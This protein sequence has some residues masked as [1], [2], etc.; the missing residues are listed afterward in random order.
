METI[1][2]TTPSKDTYKLKNWKAYNQSLCNRGSLTIWIEDSVLRSWRDI[3]S[4]KKV[5]GNKPI[6]IALYYVI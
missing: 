2:L 5:G 3:D 6:P 1:Q 4:S